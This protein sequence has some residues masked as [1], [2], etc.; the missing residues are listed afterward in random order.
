M[1]Q[2]IRFLEKNFPNSI[3]IPYLKGIL[4]VLKDFDT[5]DKK[6]Q[7]ILKHMEWQ[8]WWWEEQEF[9]KVNGLFGAGKE[10]PSPDELKERYGDYIAKSI[11]YIPRV[12][13]LEWIESKIL[14]RLKFVNH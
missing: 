8:V 7:D 6:V 4:N 3:R 2:E 12:M 14:P 1:R 5:D 11:S 13:Y 10:D 9:K